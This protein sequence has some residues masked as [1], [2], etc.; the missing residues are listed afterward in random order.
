MK[1]II[2]I[3]HTQSVHHTMK[4][5]GGWADWDLSKLGVKQAKRIGKRLSR[6]IKSEK[7]VVYASDLPRA[8]QTAEIVAGFLDVEPIFTAALREINLGDGNGKT[9]TW[10]RENDL[11]QPKTIDDR[12]YNGAESKRDLWNRLSVFYDEIM[13]SEEENIILVSHGVALGVFY[14]IWLGLDAEMLNKCGLSAS[15]G[16][17]SFMHED[18]DGKHIISR[19]NDPSYFR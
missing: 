10:A 9:K 3:P 17:I 2:A 4:V 19:L 14:A 8:K 11:G 12:Q 5:L 18:A 16:R 1:N 13:G 7:Y 6:E 15:S